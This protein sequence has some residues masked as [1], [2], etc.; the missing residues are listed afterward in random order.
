M[1]KATE[2]QLGNLHNRVAS[3]LV[4]ALEQSDAAYKLLEDYP[5]LPLK[6]KDFLED[7][8]DVNPA[9]LT[10]ATKFLKD[11]NITCDPSDSGELSELEKRLQSKRKSASITQIPLED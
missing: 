9:I 6:V 11:N 1:T 7:L 5:D 4:Q 8:V 10:N 3:V 2:N